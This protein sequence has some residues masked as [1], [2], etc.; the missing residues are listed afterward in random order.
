MLK[1][2]REET[3][4][5]RVSQHEK[6][7]IGSAAKKCGL[8]ISAYARKAI[9][10]AVPKLS[11]P[12]EFDELMQAIYK[13]H[14]ALITAGKKELADTLRTAAVAFQRAVCGPEAG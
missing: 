10:G 14:D 3:I 5:F 2:N 1:D 4:H 13:A 12:P 8:S 7:R 11:L 9:L 6:K